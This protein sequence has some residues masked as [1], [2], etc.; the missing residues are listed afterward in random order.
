[1]NLAEINTE[2]YCRK[3]VGHSTLEIRSFST[4]SPTPTDKSTEKRATQRARLTP[5]RSPLRVL[6]F[7]VL[8]WREKLTE[9]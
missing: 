6:H 4:E 5:K 1:M 3:K 8:R 9:R 7:P 2:K